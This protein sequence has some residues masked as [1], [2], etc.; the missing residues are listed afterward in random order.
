[1]YNSNSI[2]YVGLFLN[3]LILV[4]IQTILEQSLVFKTEKAVV[5]LCL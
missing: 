3:Q 4:N 1:M 2:V 5:Y